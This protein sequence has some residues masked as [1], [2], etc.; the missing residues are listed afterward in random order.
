MDTQ[1]SIVL[2]AD[3]ADLF[4]RDLKQ[5]AAKSRRGELTHVRVVGEQADQ[6][7]PWRVIVHIPGED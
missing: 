1:T 6:Q 3:E 4:A 5:A 7:G 2:T